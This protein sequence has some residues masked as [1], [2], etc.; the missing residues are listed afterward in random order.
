MAEENSQNLLHMLITVR[1]LPLELLHHIFLYA[2]APIS[3]VNQFY[4]AV[5]MDDSPYQVQNPRMTKTQLLVCR[6]WCRHRDIV[7]VSGYN[8]VGLRMCLRTPLDHHHHGNYR[9]SSIHQG[10]FATDMLFVLLQAISCHNPLH[11]LEFWDPEVASSW[12]SLEGRGVHV[13]WFDAA[14]LTM[15][16]V[17]VPH[18]ILTQQTTRISTP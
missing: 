1:L 15:L 5:L 11:W 7:A 13:R 3:S 17:D 18:A 4:G 8:F 10:H 2:V 6:Q 16:S 12:R 9:D 14:R